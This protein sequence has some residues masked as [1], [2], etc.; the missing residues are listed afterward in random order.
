MTAVHRA[1]LS[2]RGTKL[3]IAGLTVV[4]AVLATAGQAE[5]DPVVPDPAPAPADPALAPPP[6]PGGPPQVPE[7]ANPVYGSGRYGSG[8]VGTLR[9]LWHQAHDPSGFQGDGGAPE[10]VAPPPGAG[11]AP[12]LPPGYVSI[13]APGSETPVTAPAPGTG[14]AGP[15]LPPGYYSLNGPPP[16]GYQFNAPGQQPAAP[17]PAPTP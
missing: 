14:P 8:P 7:I 9:D 4:A 13:N 17:P 5:A 11:A 16:P 15:A 10:G 3:A 1:T 2:A 12:P 6:A